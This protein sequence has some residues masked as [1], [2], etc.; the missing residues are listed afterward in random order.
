MRNAESNGCRQDEFSDVCGRCE[1]NCCKEARAP[2][3]SERMRVIESNLSKVGITVEKPFEREGY[4]FPRETSEGCIFLD[5]KAKKCM[6]QS[7]KPEICVAYPVT[8]DI[9]LNKGMIEW[10]LHT[11]EICLLSGVLYRQK[12]I[13]KKHLESAKREIKAFI[14]RLQKEELL[15]ILKIEVPETFKIGEDPLEFE[16]LERVKQ[17]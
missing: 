10:Y 12:N 17:E 14:R 1:R 15:T 2:V 16:V 4:L 6:I 9:N 8:F 5:A 7:C 3:D 11:D 13:F